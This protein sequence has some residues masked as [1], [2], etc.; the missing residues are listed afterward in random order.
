MYCRFCNRRRFA[1]KAVDP[2]PYLE[3]SYAVI[4]KD[5]RIREVILSGGDP[6]MLEAGKLRSILERL[7]SM[8]KSL[9]IR[10]STRVPVVYPGGLSAGHLKAIEGASP[11]WVVIH[12]NH[13]REITEEFLTAISNIR[14]TGCMMVSQTVLLRNINDCPHVL[15]KLFESLV[16]AGVKPYYLFQLDD[17]RGASHFKVKLERGRAIMAF[18]R[19]NASGLAVPRYALD[20]P[21]GLGKIPV[22]EEHVKRL[23]DTTMVQLVSPSGEIG[24]YDDNGGE[25]ACMKCGICEEKPQSIS[26]HLPFSV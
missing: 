22:N 4:E 13:P 5:D 19:L 23:D 8:K 20:I 3:E 6:F 2:E 26:R 7:R 10:L 11:L 14:R 15:L 18:L 17:V 25:S 1:G 12:I 9:T 21:G 16:E 24:Y